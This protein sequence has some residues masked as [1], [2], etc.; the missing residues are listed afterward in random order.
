MR[1]LFRCSAPI[2]AALLLASPAFAAETYVVPITIVPG[3]LTF[4]PSGDAISGGAIPATLPLGEMVE[5][6]S[7]SPACDFGLLEFTAE[8]ESGRLVVSINGDAVGT[9]C[10]LGGSIAFDAEVVVPELGG[11]TTTVRLVPVVERFE[12]V[13]FN[14]VEAEWNR[15]EVVSA[16]IPEYPV[17]PAAEV[18]LVWDGQADDPGLSSQSLLTEPWIPGDTISFRT[19]VSLTMRG[20]SISDAQGLV[21]VRYEY[22]VTVPEPSAAISLPIGVGALLALSSMKGGA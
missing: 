13:G 19:V 7:S 18:K 16:T 5:A 14:L 6:D 8:I 10:L 9:S 22:R 17:G 21:R 2:L 3:S 11:T 4:Q 1:P 15:Q 12:F 20:N